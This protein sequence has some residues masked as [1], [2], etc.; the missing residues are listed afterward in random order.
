MLRATECG[1]LL[2]VA[3]PRYP[4]TSGRDTEPGARRALPPHGDTGPDDASRPRMAEPKTPGGLMEED[5]VATKPSQDEYMDGPSDEDARLKKPTLALDPP[6]PAP[7]RL[8]RPRS[9]PG[10]RPPPQSRQD[11]DGGITRFRSVVIAGVVLVVFRAAATTAS[12]ETVSR[13]ASTTRRRTSTRPR[14]RWPRSGA[15]PTAG[16]C[17]P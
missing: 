5:T 9:R 13:S 4:R 1:G 10:C 15:H 14:R 8:H 17:R 12:A 7:R 16:S 6:A 3:S 11:G 2:R